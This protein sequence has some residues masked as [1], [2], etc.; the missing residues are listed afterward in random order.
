MTFDF[1]NLEPYFQEGIPTEIS[2]FRNKTHP[3]VGWWLKTVIPNRMVE[4]E[5]FGFWK[6]ISNRVPY[7]VRIVDQAWDWNGEV[8]QGGASIWV[9]TGKD[10]A[11]E[12]KDDELGYAV[13]DYGDSMNAWGTILSQIL[14][15]NHDLDDPDQ[16]SNLKN[17]QAITDFM[18]KWTTDS[19]AA[20]R[21][22]NFK[23]VE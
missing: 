18:S 11:L 8:I 6:V 20:N 10:V 14:V 22:K 4:P 13:Q 19:Q 21:R 15:E 2:H 1:S 5:L 7:L 12:F 9:K 16:D 23:V 3:G 17:I